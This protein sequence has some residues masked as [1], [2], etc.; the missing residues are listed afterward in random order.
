M[1]DIGFRCRSCQTAPARWEARCGACG[2]WNR[3]ELEIVEP[4]DPA[5]LGRASRPVWSVADEPA[6]EAESA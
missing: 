6:S 2:S 5:E 3:I 4:V 1:L